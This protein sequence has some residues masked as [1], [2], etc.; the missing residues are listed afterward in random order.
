MFNET[1]F[2]NHLCERCDVI[3]NSVHHMLCEISGKDD[4]EWDM[5][6]IGEIADVAVDVLNEHGI[7]CCYPANV[8]PEDPTNPE[9]PC[10]SMAKCPIG[11]KKCP[12]SEKPSGEGSPYER[13]EES[14]QIEDEPVVPPYEY[15]VSLRNESDFG[16]N[17]LDEARAF[18]K[19][20]SSIMKAHG[21][22]ADFVMY[23]Y[24]KNT[25][26]YVEFTLTEE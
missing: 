13:H 5:S 23:Q 14:D 16:F 7:D 3:H 18:A 25:D 1:V 24:D 6:I 21:K 15:L 22:N 8:F 10:A 12:L 9:I 19:E 11:C 26:S 2:E 20:F 17:I 4:L